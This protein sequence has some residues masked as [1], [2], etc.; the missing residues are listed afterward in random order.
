MDSTDARAP[1]TPVP[2]PSPPRLHR[3]RNP[4]GATATRA[5]G[6]WRP[7]PFFV[8][9]GLFWIGVSLLALS[10]Q[11]C[12]DLGQHAAVVER[13]RASLLHPRHPAVD[14]PGAGSPYYSPYALA[15][16]VLARLF[17]LSGWETVRLA[18][19][20]N[21]LV[22][23]LGLNA[24]VKR[25][26]ANRWAS[27][28]ALLLLV[29]LWGTEPLAWSGFAGLVS[30][31]VVA[32]YPS[33]FALGL[34]L[35]TWAYAAQ[36][37]DPERADPPSRWARGGLG[38]LCGVLLLVHPVSG[39]AGVLGAAVLVL[40]RV[41]GGRGALAGEDA[42]LTG[43]GARAGDG[44][45]AGDAAPTGDRV[46]AGN[47]APTGDGV[48]AGEGAAPA[49]D[50]GPVRGAA[51]RPVRGPLPAR[52]TLRA[53]AAWW[54]VPLGA[55]LAAL[56]WFPWFD[57]FALG[58]DSAVL[59]PT[60]AALYTDVLARFWL[61]GLVALPAFGLRLRRDPRDA[62]TWMCA[63]CVAVAAYGWV[64]GHYT[65]GRV[66]GLAVL[67]AQVAVAVEVTR[68][69][70]GRALKGLAVVA[71]AGTGFVLAQSGAVL[72]EQWTPPQTRRLPAWHSYA[73]AASSVRP[74]EPVL[75][76][77]R[78]AVRSLPGF[79]IDTVAPV[80][81]DPALPEK[82]RRARWR[83]THWYLS[84][85][86]GTAR[87]A[88]I[89]RRYDIRWLLLSRW[90]RVPKEAKVLDFSRETGEVLAKLPDRKGSS[91]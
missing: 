81:S 38:A 42:A 51:D 87:R 1:Q 69:G 65:Y 6:R 30:L 12:C 76:D 9:G 71:A 61:L 10:V 49:R 39:V 40:A 46:R 56:A 91:R 50:T 53:W 37:T 2:P 83:A 41:R 26:T 78:E 74:G 88:E 44:V 4:P 90:Q 28:V 63:A 7:T 60:H 43:D 20:V 80:W 84:G 24:F 67:P 45:R 11:A 21:L 22:V 36:L 58:A 32:G 8:F 34:A 77:Q 5:L 48:R 17:G 3:R 31:P 47:A 68:A 64:S 52:A 75:T 55:L 15:E 35:L 14:L 25:F 16:G 70:R 29:T 33:T 19:P 73:W 54:P 85:R 62:L 72:P 27:T 79:G 89:A 82:E 86:A 23:L 13:L 66:L 57:V 18:A 59:D